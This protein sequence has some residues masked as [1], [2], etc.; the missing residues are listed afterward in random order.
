MTQRHYRRFLLG[1]LAYYITDLLWGILET[2]Q[3][4]GLLF[5]DTAVHFVAMAA[6]VM[7]W[8]RYVVSYLE[9]KNAFGTFLRYAGWLFLI[10]EIVVVVINCFRPILF[11]IDAD[12]SYH[13]SSARYVTLA[14]QIIL[15]LL[16]AIYTLYITS[17]T[18]GSIK[19]RHMTIGLFG[20]A[21]VV[22]IL[23][24]V[25]YP[26]FPF[27]AIGYMLGTCLLHSFVMED[28][29]EEYRRELEKAL[30]QN[31]RQTIELTES[32]EAL[33]DALRRR[34]MPTRQKPHFCQI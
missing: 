10:F 9:D 5:T 23:I 22:L 17:K 28:E 19:H 30:E 31:R 15:F 33:K 21:M 16:T 11:W 3:L 25:F 14:I 2:N 13:A 1:V 29:K 18:E 24:Q 6:A 34:K 8:T 27:Y 26:L 7:L 4:A 12:G 20:I 32:R